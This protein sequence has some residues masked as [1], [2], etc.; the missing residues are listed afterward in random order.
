MR[1]LKPVCQTMRDVHQ[2]KEHQRAR[3]EEM[4]RSRALLPA[5]HGH[6]ERKDGRHGGRHR[7]PRPDHQRS[8]H[9]NDGRVAEP[10]Q[11]VVGRELLLAGTSE[12]QVASITRRIART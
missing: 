5:E 4:N 1:A 10:L 3:H 12:A 7:Q 2:D 6:Q 9:E 11:D 8:Q